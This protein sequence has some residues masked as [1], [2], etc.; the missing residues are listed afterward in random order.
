MPMPDDTAAPAVAVAPAETIAAALESAALALGRALGDMFPRDPVE[1]RKRKARRKERKRQRQSG[2]GI[3]APK[4]A[5]RRVTFP[6]DARPAAYRKSRRRKYGVFA[7]L[8]D[9]GTAF[10]AE[11]RAAIQASIEH[12]ETAAAQRIILDELSRADAE[13]A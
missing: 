2:K 8:M 6:A 4:P 11:Q 1:E 13:G 10:S 3:I 7:P 12:G 9:V 5:P